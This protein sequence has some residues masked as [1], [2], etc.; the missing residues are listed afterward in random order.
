M[1]SQEFIHNPR[2]LAATGRIWVSMARTVASWRSRETFTC[3][4]RSARCGAWEGW[5]VDFSWFIMV[6]GIQIIIHIY[7]YTYIHTYKHIYIYTY[8]YIFFIIDKQE[9]HSSMLID[10]QNHWYVYTHNDVYLVMSSP[11]PI[12]PGVWGGCHISTAPEQG[13]CEWQ[14]G[15]HQ[16]DLYGKKNIGIW[17]NI[18]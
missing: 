2:I 16:R 12:A 11:I 8:V 3:G 17:D 13:Q 4:S 6:L 5:H 10:K 14:L 9:D 7:I 1:L 15:E 18:R